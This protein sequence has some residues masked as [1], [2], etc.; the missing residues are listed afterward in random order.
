MA[1]T[2]LEATK[3]ME[4][5]RLRME[6]V[7]AR[8]DRARG[9][10]A[11]VVPGLAAAYLTQPLM[12]TSHIFQPSLCVGIRG[13]KRIR[14]NDLVHTYDADHF[15]LTTMGLPTIVEVPQA[16]SDDPYVAVVIDLDL[17]LARATAA[18]IDISGR[19]AG[20]DDAAM[21]TAPISL[22]LAD[23]VSRLVGLLDEPADI[24]ILSRL[25][26]QEILYR[27]LTS[28]VG[29]RLRQI[30][31]MGSQHERVGRAATWLRQNLDRHIQMDDLAKMCGMGLSTLNRHFLQMTGMSPLQYQK[32][33]RLHEARRILLTESVDAA[34]AAYRVG[35][36]S[37]TQFN[38]EY[39]RLFGG[40]P[41][42]DVKTIQEAAP[43]TGAGRGGALGPPFA[44]I[45]T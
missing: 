13:M 9:G 14:L 33:M 35:Y 45:G 28:P 23:A 18:E 2:D 10:G 43:V 15:L 34:T 36:E 8:Y 6:Q 20:K 39:K 26:Q 41:I 7:I 25:L 32:Q 5:T 3:T 30:S 27:L 1:R 19:Q 16:S 11:T 24:P 29:A 42:R 21:I 22:S 12:P 4:R 37:A 17:D 31:R 40:P 44:V 38:R